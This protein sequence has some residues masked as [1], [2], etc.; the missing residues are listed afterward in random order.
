MKGSSADIP[1]WKKD[2]VARLRAQNKCTGNQ[3]L[4]V[5]GSRPSPPYQSDSAGRAPKHSHQTSVGIRPTT[6]NQLSAASGA[7]KVSSINPDKNETSA[8]FISPLTQRK[9][10]KMVQERVWSVDYSSWESGH[11]MASENENNSR[12][13]DSDSSEELHYGPGIVNKLKNKYL[14]LTLHRENQLKQRPNLRKAA[15]LEDMLDDQDDDDEE[16]VKAESETRRLFQ[17]NGVDRHTNRYRHSKRGVQDMKRARSMETISRFEN[18]ISP[19]PPSQQPQDNGRPKSMHEY[20]LIADLEEGSDKYRKPKDSKV[21]ENETNVLFNNGYV[22]RVNRP[23]RIA[24]MMNEREKPPADVVKQAKMIFEKR[25][26][27]RTKPPVNT[28]EVAAKVACYKSIIVQ[29][30]QAKKPP[31][32][33]KPAAPFLAKNGDNIAK[34]KAE[35]NKTKTEN[36]PKPEKPKTVTNGTNPPKVAPRI[37]ATSKKPQTSPV[38]SPCEET[39]TFKDEQVVEVSDKA[40]TG[41][42]K[43]AQ[44]PG[45]IPDVSLVK[46][47]QDTTGRLCHTPD[48]IM[49]INPIAVSTP[50]YESSDNTPKEC[51]NHEIL[52]SVTT[53]RCAVDGT[54]HQVDQTST[55]DAVPLN[56]PLKLIINYNRSSPTSEESP[57]LSQISPI[58]RRKIVSPPIRP[59]KDP[60]LEKNLIN[61]AK[62]LEQ[63]KVEDRADVFVPKKVKRPPREPESN[64]IVFKFTDRKDVPDYVQNDRSRSVGKLERPKV[65]EG[66]IILLPGAAIDESFTDEDEEIRK[67]LEAPPSPCDVTFINDNIL[68]DGK[69]SIKHKAKRSRMRISFVESGPDVFEYPSESSLLVDESPTSIPSSPPMTGHAVPNL[70]GSYLAN[71]IPKSTEE[72][73]PGVSRSV[74]PL[75]P[76]PTKE[77]QIEEDDQALLEEVEQPVTFSAGTNSDMLF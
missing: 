48:L 38:L 10:C 9:T 67:Y 17:T 7:A 34:S 35:D 15:S 51:Y 76:P 46:V 65:G 11:N 5:C 57:R 43:P 28:G 4:T 56:E 18:M 21:G 69:S 41:K 19:P 60:V 36:K 6:C 50:S 74:H 32:K 8:K 54:L 55:K 73:Q 16:S 26:E 31:V 40:V 62:S 70:S 61:A 27:Q 71:Y 3:A 2:L 68:I 64:S 37:R 13:S 24:P 66:G 47:E 33:T 58:P 75:T 72:F 29:S 30:K 14:S 44:L 12:T 53:D 49:T 1:V 25:P 59:P 63:S 45:L 22:P 39:K 77:E 52:E 23:K 42:V 20:L